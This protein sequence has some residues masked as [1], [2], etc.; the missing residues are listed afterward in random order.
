MKK[1]YARYV[2]EG[3]TAQ[4]IYEAMETARCE[5]ELETCWC[6]AGNIDAKIAL[7]DRQKDIEKSKKDLKHR[8]QTRLVF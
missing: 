6:T 1:T 4:E 2:P 5:A 3:G 8:C 7:R